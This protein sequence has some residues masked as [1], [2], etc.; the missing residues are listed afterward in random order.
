MVMNYPELIAQEHADFVKKNDRETQFKEAYPL[1][2]KKN[3]K[4]SAYLHNLLLCLYRTALT[5]KSHLEAYSI[6]WTTS[7][8]PPVD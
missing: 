3:A 1:R 6:K 8:E 4:I 5:F 2:D 7:G